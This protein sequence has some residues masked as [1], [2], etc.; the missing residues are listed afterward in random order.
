MERYE[1]WAKLIDAFT[2]V[3]LAL[4]SWACW[5]ASQWI[6]EKVKDSRLQHVLTLLCET[7]PNVVE[8][9]EQTLVWNLKVKRGAAGKL[10]EEQS[11]E[12]KTKAI[13][14]V[15]SQL[16][17]EFR[18]LVKITGSEGAAKSVIESRIESQ[19]FSMRRIV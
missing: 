10:T 7:I 16:G 1:L 14:K 2:P 15:V 5:K 12:V 18:Q 4:V 8:E 19:V 13:D 11:N 3:L 6:D 17:P 9:M